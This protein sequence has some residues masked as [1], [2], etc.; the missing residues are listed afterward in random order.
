MPTG[1]HIGSEIGVYRYSR[2]G[3]AS[4][5][6]PERVSG[7]SRSVVR[8]DPLRADGDRIAQKLKLIPAS[9]FRMPLTAVGLAKNGDVIVP[10]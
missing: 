3:T 9:I 8:I 6:W 5:E 1:P 4:G 7:Q 10:L 2:S